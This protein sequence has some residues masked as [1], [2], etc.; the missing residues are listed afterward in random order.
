MLG[1]FLIICIAVYLSIKLKIYLLLKNDYSGQVELDSGGRTYNVCRRAAVLHI[2]SY[3]VALIGYIGCM[4][5]YLF[6]GEVD[7]SDYI[8]GIAELAIV[9]ILIIAVICYLEIRNAQGYIR[10]SKDEIEYKRRKCFSVKITDIKKIIFIS[11]YSWNIELKEKGKKHLNINLSEFYNRKE[12]SSLMQQL[13]DYSAKI[14]GREKSIT[15]KLGLWR[16][17]TI[18]GKYYLSGFKIIIVLLLLYGSY[19]CID[20]D[21]FKK[22]YTAM[23]NA[24]GTDSSQTENAWPHYVQAAVNYVK[25]E[26]G[27]QKI[28]DDSEKSDLSNLTDGQKDDLRKWF[29]ENAS[30]WASLK[31]ATSISYCNASYTHIYI[32]DNTELNDFSNPSDSGYIPIARLYSNI[33]AGRF[34][35]VIDLDW[36]DLFQMQLASSKHFVNG[37]TFTD[38]FIG[39]AAIRRSIKLLAE[40]DSYSIE[41]LQ[42]TRKTLRECFPEGLPPLSSEGEILRIC[43]TF[44][45]FINLK[46]IP[47]Q[48][49]LN[50]VF[51]MYGSR[52]GS[53]KSVRKCYAAILEKAQKGIKVEPKGFSIIN[54]PIMRNNMLHILDASD[55]IDRKPQRANTTLSAAYFLLDLEEYKLNKGCYPADVSQLKKA[56]LTSQLPDDPDS[57]GKIIYRN[58]GQRAILYAV[59][60]NAKD[61]DGYKEYKSTDKNRE[62]RDD[63]VYWQRNLKEQKQ[64]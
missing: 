45:Y 63:I 46:K 38:Q 22:D 42:K 10:I 48:T 30:S 59:G 34:A 54:F 60:A 20:Y 3:I 1:I 16:L 6:V 7:K 13:R 33:S 62:K 27:L 64:P 43:S 31:K 61:D 50:P 4:W 55:M 56:G 19:C 52:I 15:Y 17:E 11:M 24:L 35:G 14:S 23:F 29:D 53:E 18:L 25:L 47:V 41:D 12:I 49:P 40:Q 5:P 37:K 8:I 21:F 28:I 9:P 39:Y 36:F 44:D 2:F 32:G 51:L 57:G 26:D 58:D